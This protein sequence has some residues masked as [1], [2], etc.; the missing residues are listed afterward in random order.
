MTDIIV[1][2]ILCVIAIL[3]IRRLIINYKK[4]GSCAA[5]EEAQ[6]GHCDHVGHKELDAR[7]VELD[8]FKLN[9]VQKAILAKHARE[10][11]ENCKK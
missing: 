7:R 3:I 5:C 1:I 8:K 4:F 9:E 6:L 11:T 2:G 10:K